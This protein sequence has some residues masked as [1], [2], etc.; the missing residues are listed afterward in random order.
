MLAALGVVV[1]CVG[2]VSCEAVGGGLFLYILGIFYKRHLL[3]L[4][5]SVTTFVRT[6]YI[7]HFNLLFVCK[8]SADETFELCY[9]SYCISM[10]YFSIP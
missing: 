5:T 6:A 1:G 2:V 8:V 7:G 9:T 4:R 3:S 10:N